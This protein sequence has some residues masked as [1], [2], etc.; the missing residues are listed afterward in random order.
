MRLATRNKLEARSMVGAELMI[1][2]VIPH[3]AY[4][5]HAS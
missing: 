2:S 5:T 1:G 4:G 3:Q